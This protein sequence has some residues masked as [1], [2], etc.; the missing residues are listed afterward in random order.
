MPKVT[1]RREC[2]LEVCPTPPQCRT[3]ELVTAVSKKPSG[4]S[5]RLRWCQPCEKKSKDCTPQST[6]SKQNVSDAAW[7]KHPGGSINERRHLC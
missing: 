7:P 2:D 6:C 1:A 4:F 3:G 5:T